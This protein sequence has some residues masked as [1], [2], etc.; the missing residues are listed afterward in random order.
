[1]ASTA[2]MD[3]SGMASFIVVCGWYSEVTGREWGFRWEI[4]EEVWKKKE[5]GD[6]EDDEEEVE[7]EEDEKEGFLF[8]LMRVLMLCGWFPF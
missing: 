3:T 7:N 6:V 4:K 1:M 8:S 5:E 2:V